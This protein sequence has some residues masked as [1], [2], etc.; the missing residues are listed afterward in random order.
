M[1]MMSSWVEGEVT[2]T[3][4]IMGKVTVAATLEHLEDVYAFRKGALAADQVRRVD[5]ADALIDSGATGLLVPSRLIGSLGLGLIKERT[6][7]TIIG[8]TTVRVF[9]AVQLTIQGRDCISDVTEIADTLP[10]I[11]GQV[12]L[13]LM[14]WV[15]DMKGRKLIGNPEHGGEDMIEVLASVEFEPGVRDGCDSLLNNQL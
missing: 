8:S 10:V 3:T 4:E 15:I 6:A 7:K 12:P 5:V 13:E 1:G 14:D 11:V 2:V 9:Q